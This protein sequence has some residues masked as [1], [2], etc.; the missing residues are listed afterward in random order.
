M[1]SV[2]FKA[3]TK[4]VEAL[5]KKNLEQGLSEGSDFVLQKIKNETPVDTGNLRQSNEKKKISYDAVV[6]HNTADYANYVEAGTYKQSANP[7]FRRGLIAS[8]RD[9]FRILINNMRKF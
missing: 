3:N 9:F 8:S 6:L 1:I 4:S 7:F 5:F 2:K